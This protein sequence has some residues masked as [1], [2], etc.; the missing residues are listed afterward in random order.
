[1]NLQACSLNVLSVVACADEH[2]AEMAEA[3]SIAVV[4]AVAAAEGLTSPLG[5]E[6]PLSQSKW[7]AILLQQ[8]IRRLRSKVR[9]Q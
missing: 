9:R 7:R 4:D 6:S 5:K 8:G 2:A 1:M 3:V